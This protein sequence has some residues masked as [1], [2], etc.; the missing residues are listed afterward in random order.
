MSHQTIAIKLD[1]PREILWGDVA[2][3]R[4]GTLTRPPEL[5][6]LKNPRKCY[7]A[8]L[9]ILWAALQDSEDMTGPEAL[10]PFFQT[11]AAVKAGVTAI[12]DML[13]RDIAVD[14]KKSTS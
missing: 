7:S 14:Q 10:V 1:R 9:G 11:D 5:Q 6:D 13:R 2:R 4:L 3:Y 12:A 8:M